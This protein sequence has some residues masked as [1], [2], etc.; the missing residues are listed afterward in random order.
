MA[1]HERCPTCY[2]G[3]SFLVPVWEDMDDYEAGEMADYVGCTECH[4]MHDA[5]AVA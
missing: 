3:S 4:T 2:A 1:P 5:E